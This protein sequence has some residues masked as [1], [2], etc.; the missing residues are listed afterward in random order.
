M[1]YRELF[2]TTTFRLTMLYGLIFAVGTLALLWMVYLRSA[3]YLTGRVDGILN[4]EADA[5]LRSPR[6]GLRQRL[7]EDLTLNGDRTNVFGLF[8]ASGERLAGNLDALPAMLRTNEKPA[9]LPPTAQFPGSVR[10]IA[11]GLPTGEVLVVG[12]DVSQLREMRSII[13]SA[14][15]W[16]G[17]SILLVGLACGTALSIAPLKRVRRLQAVA[18]NIAD[19][20]LH[21]RM[22]TSERRDELDMFAMT[23]N[24]TMDEVERLMSEVQATTAVIAHDLLNPLANAALKL[25]RL[26][27]AETVQRDDIGPIGSRLEEVLDRFRAILRLAEL[28]SRHRRAGFI[29]VDLADVIVPAEDLY[30]PL[31][32][33]AGVQFLVAAERGTTVDADPKLLFEA[34]SNLID[35]AIKYAGRGHTVRVRTGNDPVRPRIIVEDDGPGIPSNERAA[36]LQRFYRAERQRDTAGSGLGL[37]VVAAIV[38]LHGFNLMLEDAGPGVR[39]VIEVRPSA[40]HDR[41]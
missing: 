24:H 17:V 20:D 10:L 22:P 27:Q 14:L 28:E 23:I 12:R 7:I 31:A 26:Q 16:S 41:A 37:S 21:L 39:A 40:D 35:N 4:T 2:R 15:L 25:R 38:R 11:R 33:D 19:G 8:A 30:S 36:V 9:E 3:V 32:E 1:E 5:L 6:P 34:V 18:K 13:T 29:R